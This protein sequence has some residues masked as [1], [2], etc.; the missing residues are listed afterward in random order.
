[1]ILLLVK[2]ILFAYYSTDE[3]EASTRDKIFNKS[4]KDGTA[5]KTTTVNSAQD[6]FFAIASFGWSK[7]EMKFNSIMIFIQLKLISVDADTHTQKYI[8]KQPK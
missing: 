7:K 2:S 1:M 6:F 3:Y 8:L 4:G 5:T